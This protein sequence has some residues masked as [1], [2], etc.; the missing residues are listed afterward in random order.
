MPRDY[1]LGGGSVGLAVYDDRLEVTSTGPLHFGL[2]PAALPGLAAGRRAKSKAGLA[3]SVQF[4][5]QAVDADQYPETDVATE[6][7]NAQQDGHLPGD[8]I[9]RGQVD[10]ESDEA[11]EGSG[12]KGSRHEGG[13]FQ[14]SACFP[15]TAS[16]QRPGST[17]LPSHSAP[18]V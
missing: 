16:V 6:Q 11:E 14:I 3:P 15:A 13:C 9:R 17:A 1:A 4:V 7:R 10:D 8:D 12:D 18:D 2:T 5:D